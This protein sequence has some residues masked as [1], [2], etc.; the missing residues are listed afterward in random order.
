MRNNPPVNP[1]D[2]VFD[3]VQT[4]TFTTGMQPHTDHA[5]GASVR[6]CVFTAQALT[7]QKNAALVG[8]F[9]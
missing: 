2:S 4:S 9:A 6:V 1:Q 8:V 3:D 5:D 7:G